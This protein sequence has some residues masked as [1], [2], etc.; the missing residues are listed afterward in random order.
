M[1]KKPREAVD[2]LQQA[3]EMNYSPGKVFYE[4]AKAHVLLN[5][6]NEAINCLQKAVDHGFTLRKHYIARSEILS[7]LTKN[8]EF[9]KLATDN[10]NTENSEQSSSE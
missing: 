5:D 8:P 2:D 9:S 1:C 3:L 7:K 10:R 6:E 4:M